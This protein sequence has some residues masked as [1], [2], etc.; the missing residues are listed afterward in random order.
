[1]SWLTAIE[2]NIR[3]GK[4][5]TALY[6][7]IL[8][9]TSMIESND[10]MTDRCKDIIKAMEDFIQKTDPESLKDLDM[11]HFLVEGEQALIF[12]GYRDKIDDLLKTAMKQTEK[13]RYED[14]ILDKSK[15]ASTLFEISNGDRVVRGRSF[16]YWLAPATIVDLI[17]TSNNEELQLFRYALGNYYGKN[18]YYENMAD[19]YEHLLEIKTLLETA[20][21]STWGQIKKQYQKWIL[22]DI[23]HYLQAMEFRLKT[24]K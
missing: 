23:N 5:S 7:D 8:Y 21:V 9:Y 22:G 14:A 1:M 17:E 6:T 16:V 24:G 13:Q 4:Y 12:R 11:E 2:N 3:I 18:V 15:W 20:D 19:D 10:V